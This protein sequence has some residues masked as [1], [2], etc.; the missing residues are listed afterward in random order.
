MKK[1]KILHLAGPA[2]KRGAEVFARRLSDRLR[3]KGID[4]RIFFYPQDKND[5]RVYPQILGLIR[6]QEPNIIHLHWSRYLRHLYPLKRLNRLQDVAIV[7]TQIGFSSFFVKSKMK[8]RLAAHLTDTVCERVIAVCNAVMDDFQETFPWV[9]KNKLVI[10]NNGVDVEEI[11]NSAGEREELR[12]SMGIR[13]EETLIVCVSAFSPE[14]NQAFILRCLSEIKGR[15]WRMI[16]VGDGPNRPDCEHLA[17]ELGLA[18]RVA[19]VGERDDV[20]KFL[21][22]SDIFVLPSLTEGLSVALI[23]AGVMGLPALASNKGGNHEVVSDGLTGFILPL[24]GQPWIEKLNELITN[25]EMRTSMGKEAS[26][27]CRQKFNLE[28]SVKQHIEL[29]QEVLCGK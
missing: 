20:A 25:P 28:D 7:K 1:I 24:Q 17:K 4:S 2:I 5:I 29:Y 23:E 18:E 8:A 10:I 14:K 13:P 3:D 9:P 19:F 12:S 27:F 6:E 26:S 11:L 22:A 16:F 21:N 15:N